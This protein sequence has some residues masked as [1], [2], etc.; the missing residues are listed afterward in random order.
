MAKK[1]KDDDIKVIESDIA[2]MQNRP[3]MY[4]ASLGQAGCLHICKEIIDNNRDECFKKESIGDSITIDITRDRIITSDNGRGIPTNLLRV[5]HET[6]Q[7]GSNMVRSGGATSG[8][9]G[10]GTTLSCAMA[11]KLIVTTFRPVE[12]KKLTLEYNDGI[13]VREELENYTGDRSGLETTFYP[14][15]KVLG[16]DKIPVEDLY[17]W[18]KDMD[19]TLP[20]GINIEYTINGKKYHVQHKDLEEYLKDALKEN[21]DDNEVEYLCEPL[22]IHVSGKLKEIVLEKEYNRSFEVEALIAYTVPEYRNDDI[23]TSWMNMIYTMQNGTHMDGVIKGF[24]KAITDAVCKRKKTLEGENLT[25]DIN[26]HLQVVVRASCDFANL[27]SSQAKHH[28]WPTNLEKAIIDSVESYVSKLG[29]SKLGDICEV[30]IANNRARKAGEQARDI[31]KQTRT[32]QWEKITSFIPCSTVKTPEPKELFLVE[33][34]SA[35]GGLRGCRDAKYQAILQFRGKS[36]NI[37]DCDLERTMKSDSWSDLIKVLGCGIGPTFDI[38]KLKFDKIII[39][40]DADIDG[41]HIRV[42]FLSFFLKFLP[43]IIEEG[44]LYIAE[45]PLY[46][47]KQKGC[48]DFTYVATQT[49]YIEKCIQ[50][51]GN[52]AISFPER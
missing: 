49:E 23:R 39:A 28:V 41:Y 40:T 45:P 52:I 14:S 1:F 12:K 50:S 19:Y 26:A 32:K 22:K 11:K 31:N 18:I 33:G 30:V 21:N 42:G 36:L 43:E 20:K 13:L 44:R 3:S 51:V 5:V 4:L 15:K 34:L 10:T 8:E 46:A 17:R 35:G 47:L 37:W 25:K 27:F 16:V 38:K 9:N 7:A 6:N 2:K 48:K 29:P 24:S